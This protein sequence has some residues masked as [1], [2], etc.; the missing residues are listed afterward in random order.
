MKKQNDQ[1]GQGEIHFWSSGHLVIW[2]L[3]IC[4]RDNKLFPRSKSTRHHFSINVGG[5]EMPP[6]TEV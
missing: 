5:A 2:L 4:L 3:R 6:W 1:L